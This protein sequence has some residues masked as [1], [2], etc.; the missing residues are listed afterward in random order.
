[1]GKGEALGGKGGGNRGG[2]GGSKLK[3]TFIFVN[4]ATCVD[5]CV[6]GYGEMYDGWNGNVLMKAALHRVLGSET[7]TTTCQ[8]G[9]HF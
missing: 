5:I 8:R 7:D 3:K 4:L 1:V 6:S 9:H 2:K